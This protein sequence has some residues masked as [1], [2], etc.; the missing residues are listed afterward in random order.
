MFTLRATWAQ[1]PGDQKKMELFPNLVNAKV[2]VFGRQYRQN[3]RGE[4]IAS[5]TRDA[6]SRNNRKWYD[7][8]DKPCC[9]GHESDVLPPCCRPCA[10]TVG[11]RA[12]SQPDNEHGFSAHI[13]KCVKQVVVRFSAS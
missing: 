11:R 2:S 10:G 3:Q 8:K 1:F 12:G 7:S 4:Y 5:V 9:V 13:Q 6:R